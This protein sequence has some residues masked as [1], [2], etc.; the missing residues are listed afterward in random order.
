M[1]QATIAV[2]VFGLRDGLYELLE[3]MSRTLN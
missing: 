1:K 3:G 2:R